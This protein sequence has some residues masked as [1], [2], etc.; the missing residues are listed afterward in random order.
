M[1]WLKCEYLTTEE[2]AALSLGR[3]PEKISE[4]LNEQHLGLDVIQSKIK[5]TMRI[6]NRLKSVRTGD[7]LLSQ[8]EFIE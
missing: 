2:A 8:S 4:I 5:E 6:L 3:N 1:H 7:G